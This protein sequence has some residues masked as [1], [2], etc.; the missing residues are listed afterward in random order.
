MVINSV[1]PI[2]LESFVDLPGVKAVVWAGLPGQ[3]AG[4]ALVDVLY[5]ATSPN[6]KLPYSIAKTAKDFGSTMES[7]TDN[8]REGL[9]IDYKHMDK[10]NIQPRYEFGFGLCKFYISGCVLSLY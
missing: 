7:M 6:G 5:G 3:E 10:N 8:F 1:G 9:F 2:L 4:N